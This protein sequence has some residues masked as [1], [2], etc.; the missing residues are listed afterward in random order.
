MN[1]NI[2]TA[3]SQTRIPTSSG[4]PT[5]MKLQSD[6]EDRIGCDASLG[7]SRL[8]ARQCGVE[9]RRRSYGTLRIEVNG[10]QQWHGFFFMP[11]NLS[12]GA[13]ALL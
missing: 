9:R 12:Q 8:H 3:E 5:F 2:A 10:S 6:P 7:V 4:S 1:N 13:W 11:A